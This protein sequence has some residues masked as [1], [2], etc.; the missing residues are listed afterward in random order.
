MPLGVKLGSNYLQMWRYNRVCLKCKTPQLID[1]LIFSI[2]HLLFRASDFDPYPKK[3]YFPPSTM[4]DEHLYL[5]G[6]RSVGLFLNGIPHDIVTGPSFFMVNHG[7]TPIF[8]HIPRL[9]RRS[10]DPET[11]PRWTGGVGLEAQFLWEFA[12][13]RQVN[14]GNHVEDWLFRQTHGKWTRWIGDWIKKHG[15]WTMKNRWYAIEWFICWG[16]ITY[17]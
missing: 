11:G 8:H 10:K 6:S 2:S 7:K 14:G 12:K 3:W 9:Y 4:K 1:L 16:I 15:K 5:I 13:N 17:W